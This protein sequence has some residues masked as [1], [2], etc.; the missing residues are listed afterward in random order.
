MSRR[1]NN[2]STGKVKDRANI[3]LKPDERDTYKS[4][5]LQRKVQRSSSWSPK[6]PQNV[7]EIKNDR[8]NSHEFKSGNGTMGSLQTHP[9]NPAVSRSH[10]NSFLPV[11][12]FFTVSIPQQIDTTMNKESS[13]K[14]DG[15][16]QSCLLLNPYHPLDDCFDA[17]E[18]M[19]GYE[20]E[21]SVGIDL[22]L[23][24]EMTS[25]KLNISGL[26]YFCIIQVT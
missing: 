10:S 21:Y 24:T 18:E 23:A 13:E 11:S 1:W 20:D 17:D 8:L 16:A 5:V 25:G 6:K 9:A 22:P 4:P 7:S 14:L 19:S 2:I 12:T 26:V 3:Y 15:S